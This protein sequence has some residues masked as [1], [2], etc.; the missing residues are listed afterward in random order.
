[1]SWVIWVLTSND[2]RL[3]PEPLLSRCPPI[4]LCHLTL[5]E[6][7]AFVRRE[8]AKR[9]LSEASVE[10]IC[11][12]LSHPS[13]RQHRPRLRVATRMLQRVADLE[14]GLTLH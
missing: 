12:I 8:G 7:L 13:L 6:L 4:R 3:L 5:A 1:M 2:F 11:E 14:Q 9:A 10:A